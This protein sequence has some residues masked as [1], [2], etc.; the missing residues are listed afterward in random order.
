[1]VYMMA[2][3]MTYDDTC[4]LVFLLIASLIFSRNDLLFI[5]LSKNFLS[6]CKSMIKESFTYGILVKQSSFYLLD[7]LLRG[8]RMT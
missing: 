6:A 2:Y 1:M 3:W 8:A 4:K 7:E 5:Y